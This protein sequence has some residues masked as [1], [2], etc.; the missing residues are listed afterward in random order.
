MAAFDAWLNSPVTKS[1]Q[2]ADERR[3]Q[4]LHALQRGE[5]PT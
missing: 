1:D 3:E 4:R 5:I 2:L